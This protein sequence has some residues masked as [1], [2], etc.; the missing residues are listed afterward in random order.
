METDNQNIIKEEEMNKIENEITKR[1]KKTI[2]GR[3]ISKLGL[4]K[5]IE[6][7][8]KDKNYIRE[9]WQVYYAI[10]RIK[11]NLKHIKLYGNLS[12]EQIE[13]TSDFCWG[14]IISPFIWALINKLY[15][16]AIA[17]IIPLLN[18]Y[19]R[20]KLFFDGKKIAWEKGE[21]KNF[22]HF[23]E[24][25]I[26]IDIFLVILILFTISSIVVVIIFT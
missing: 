25:Q 1:I 19:I 16:W 14:A 10:E 15:L 21:W 23:K 8:V 2:Q 22:K 18:I 6:A 20:F 11:E 9:D 3:E 7:E 12:L 24:T 5:M 13:F 17:S 26:N 4:N